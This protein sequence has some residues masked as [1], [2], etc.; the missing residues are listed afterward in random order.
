MISLGD[1]S[2]MLSLD[3]ESGCPAMMCALGM[4]SQAWHIVHAPFLNKKGVSYTAYCSR[5]SVGSR[6]SVPTILRKLFIVGVVLKLIIRSAYA[7]LLLYTE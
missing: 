5:V 2:F 4:L 1:T 6:S 7:L 3:S